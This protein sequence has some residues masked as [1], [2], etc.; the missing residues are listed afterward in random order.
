[1][2]SIRNTCPIQH[3]HSLHILIKAHQSYLSFNTPSHAPM[4]SVSF[5]DDT[6]LAS[7]HLVELATAGA[8]DEISNSPGSVRDYIRNR[9]IVRDGK[10]NRALLF[11]IYQ[12]GR[13]G[14]QNGFRLCLVHEGFAVDED[15]AGEKAEAPVAQG[16]TEFIR[17]GTP[18]PPI[19]EP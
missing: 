10:T 6:P 4:A 17:L 16:V 15:V 13:Y 11:V 1:V 12:T 18:R 5:S 14:P 8:L 2:L 3:S 19:A 7:S 9:G